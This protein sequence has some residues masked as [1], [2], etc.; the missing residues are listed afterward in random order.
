MGDTSERIKT[1]KIFRKEYCMWQ[2]LSA[3]SGISLLTMQLQMVCY[4][5]QT[6]RQSLLRRK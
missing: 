1:N 6:I 4:Y 3:R 5:L 2:L